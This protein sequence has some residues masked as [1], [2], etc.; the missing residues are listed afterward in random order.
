MDGLPSLFGCTIA[1]FPGSVFFFSPS[2][3]QMQTNMRPRD[4]QGI[5]EI[6]QRMIRLSISLLLSLRMKDLVLDALSLRHCTTSSCRQITVSTALSGCL[7][8]G[9]QYSRLPR[10][11]RYGIQHRR[12]RVIRTHGAL[13]L[14]A[15]VVSAWSNLEAAGNQLVESP[16]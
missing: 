1:A 8:C 15:G 3:A 13:L 16:H 7:P 12:Q 10:D 9:P 14:N 2:Y 4:R 6:S 5:A 11:S